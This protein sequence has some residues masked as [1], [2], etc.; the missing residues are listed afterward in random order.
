MS[1]PLV[2]HYA[3]LKKTKLSL[4][5]V[6]CNQISWVGEQ[7][8]RVLGQNPGDQEF[9][10]HFRYKGSRIDTHFQPQEVDKGKT[11]SKKNSGICPD[12]HQEQQ[13]PKV[14]CTPTYPPSFTHTYQLYNTTHCFISLFDICGLC[15]G[16]Y[17]IPLKM[18]IPFY[19]MTLKNHFYRKI[20]CQIYKYTC[21]HTLSVYLWD[22]TQYS[23]Y[24]SIPSIV[25]L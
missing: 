24:I 7:T 13:R 11:L 3:A 12:N 23:I 20:S 17:L 10:S 6:K 18:L 8:K 5:T 2:Y 4:F 14:I 25:N 21:I 1:S 19:L 9:Q 16:T 22:A 15:M